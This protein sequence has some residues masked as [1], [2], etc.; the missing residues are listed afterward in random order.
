MDDVPNSAVDLLVQDKV[1]SSSFESLFKDCVVIII[2][3]FLVN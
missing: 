1:N 3:P 2:T